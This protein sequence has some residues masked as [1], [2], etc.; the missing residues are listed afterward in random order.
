MTALPTFSEICRKPVLFF[1]L[2]FGSGLL[3]KA[4]GTWGSIFALGLYCLIFPY[5]PLAWAA[6]ALL[7]SFIVGIWF[8]AAAASALG[9]HDHGA[10]VW[11]EFVGQWMVVYYLQRVG[12]FS[13]L[14]SL[15]MG[16][17]LFRLF[18]IV[19]P[20]PIR[21]FDRKVHGGLGVM[22]DDVLAAI[23]AIGVVFIVEFF[24]LIGFL[25]A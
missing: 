20:W 18:D 22:L 21:W 1:A 24:G 7:V 3:P 23:M 17:V 2:G 25:V 15:L 12:E 4:P 13:L 5:L 11:D 19:K 8:C 14:W 10:V 6:L 9:A 16:F